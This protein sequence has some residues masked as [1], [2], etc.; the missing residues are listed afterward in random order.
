MTRHNT[1][2]Q[3]AEIGTLVAIFYTSSLIFLLAAL[4]AALAKLCLSNYLQHKGETWIERRADCQRKLDALEKWRFDLFLKSPTVV[5]LI[6]AL[7]LF[8]G[9]YRQLWDIH[10]AAP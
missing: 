2:D 10:P 4:L 5:F 8:C 3:I 1:D 6:G 9:F 7:L